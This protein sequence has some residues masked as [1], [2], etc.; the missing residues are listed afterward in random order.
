MADLV[1]A[2]DQGTTSTRCILFD[3]AGTAVGSHQI[4]HDQIMPRAGWVEHD[5][6][7]IWQ[8]TET[9]V[10]QS[11][12]AGGAQ[13]LRH[14]R[15]RHHQPAR[16]HDRVGPAD[17]SAVPQRHRLAGHPDRPAGRRAG[18]GG[19]GRPDPGAGRHPA[20]HLLRRRQAGVAAGAGGRRS[21]PAAEAG[22]ALFGTIDTWLLWNLTGGADGGRHLTDVTNASRTMLMNLAELRWDD[23]AA[24]AA[25]TSPGRCCP[26][27]CRPPIPKRSAPPGSAFDGEVVIGGVLGDQHAAM[28][29]Q[30]CLDEGEAKNTYGT[31]NFLLINT[32]T[33]IVPL[34]PRAAQHRLLPVRRRAGPVRPGGLDRGHRL[35][36]PV[37]ARPAR[38]R[39]QRR[40][41][42]PA[43]RIGARH[44]RALLRPGVLRAVRARTGGRT[45]A[46]PSSG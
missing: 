35:G 37:A 28:V 4:E 33:E 2:I 13:R 14:R 29:G 23:R 12:A 44:R 15:G 32:G 8:R 16:D 6:L 26:R 22:D 43:G 39:L 21:A 46:A 9:V 31:G 7:Q 40:R 17:R 36:H 24:G 5:P 42:G 41:G 18:P 10:Q 45:P 27:S 25:S 11:M 38:H 20:G 3:R 30:V 34:H 1:A 19:H